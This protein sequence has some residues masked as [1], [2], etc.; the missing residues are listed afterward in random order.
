MPWR[1]R[2]G[3]I[4]G[5]TMMLFGPGL[6]TG[7]GAERLT[8]QVWGG[9]WE[10]GARAVGDVFAKRSGAEVRYELQVN[11][12]EGIA[13]IRAQRANP[14]VDVLFSTAD[15]LQQATEE[16]LL[17]PLNR[18]LAPNLASLPPQAVEKTS[19]QF[20][21]LLFGMGYRRDLVPF[22]LRRYE[23]LVDPRLKGRV[24]SPTAMYSSGR[25]IVMA[26]LINGGNERNIDPAFD[27]LRK[28]K[29][30]ITT[31][32]VGTDPLQ[33]LQ[34]GEAGVVP[35]L[36]LSD[37]AKLLGPNSQYRFVLPE[38]SPVLMNVNA[39][40]IPNPKNAELAHRF[41]DYLATA[42]AQEAFCAKAICTPVHPGAQPPDVMR[43]FR[44]RPERIYSPDWTVIN[45][46]LPAW[47]ERF[48]KEIQAR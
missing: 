31:F 14:Q 48:K 23:D 27:F 22:E 46:S 47:D 7:W 9:V 30:N 11:T 20:S 10:E 38:G 45:K 43:E 29:P 35:L 36:I 39:V 42:E 15:A 32:V 2:V 37:I 18:S 4:S 24:G 33:V 21:Y 28:M 44:P 8:L 1:A 25:W 16:G 19:A 5:I 17:V 13:R 26:A 3:V 34:S 41:I 40:G 12:R 6:E